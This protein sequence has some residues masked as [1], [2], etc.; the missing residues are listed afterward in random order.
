MNFY[1]NICSVIEIRG[2]CILFPFPFFTSNGGA[3]AGFWIF[4][5]F[6]LYFG[7]YS[8]SFVS[9]SD[10]PPEQYALEIAGTDQFFFLLSLLFQLVQNCLFYHFLNRKHKHTHGYI[11]FMVNQSI[12]KRILMV[13]CWFNPDCLICN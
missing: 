13:K 9:K 8:A 5:N 6:A 10:I 1:G 3:V 2:A 12:K 7:R 4:L 11:F